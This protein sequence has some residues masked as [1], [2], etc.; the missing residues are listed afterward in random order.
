MVLSAFVLIFI[1][2]SAWPV[3]PLYEHPAYFRS[4]DL[5]TYTTPNLHAYRRS[6]VATIHR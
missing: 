2:P 3:L 6:P 1:A 5:A 4:P